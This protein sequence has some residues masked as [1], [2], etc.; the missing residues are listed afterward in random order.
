MYKSPQAILPKF[1]WKHIITC[2]TYAD[3]VKLT[4]LDSQFNKLIDEDAGRSS[5]LQYRCTN[6][7]IVKC[8]ELRINYFWKYALDTYT[9]CDTIDEMLLY[10]TNDIACIDKFTY[11]K[12]FFKSGKYLFNNN[13]Y[14]YHRCNTNPCSIE[15]NGSKSET[16]TFKYNG[17]LNIGRQVPHDIYHNTPMTIAILVPKYLSIKYI[18]FYSLKCDLGKYGNDKC[19]YLTNAEFSYIYDYA[20]IHISNC[21]F[22]E[23]ESC[24]FIR[25]INKSTISNCQYTNLYTGIYICSYF[26]DINIINKLKAIKSIDNIE[27]N[28]S[29]STFLMRSLPGY[30]AYV[31]SCYKMTMDSKINFLNNIVLN[32]NILIQQP[33]SHKTTDNN[34]KICIS[35]NKIYNVDNCLSYS[36]NVHL[37]DNYFNNIISLQDGCG[38]IMLDNSNMFDNCGKR[39]TDQIALLKN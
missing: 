15:I 22:D 34:A 23:Y 32:T 37:T 28:I 6:I 7:A 25:S 4:M 35:N 9:S 29:C 14:V 12:I 20:E 21:A 19:S 27:C 26:Y 38:N 24:L 2:L 10:I 39:C 17:D 3:I 5:F 36:N 31:I 18:R 13:K 1:L 30:Q 16:T 11:Y 33:Y 8:D